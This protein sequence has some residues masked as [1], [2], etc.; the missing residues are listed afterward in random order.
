MSTN[1]IK[2][3]K[4]FIFIS[5]KINNLSRISNSEQYDHQYYPSLSL[6]K[7]EEKLQQNLFSQENDINNNCS[8]DS[9]FNNEQYLNLP[10]IINF[11]FTDKS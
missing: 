5:S 7:N 4:I 9:L 3:I 8:Q 6:Y 2:D 10:R 1:V 11:S